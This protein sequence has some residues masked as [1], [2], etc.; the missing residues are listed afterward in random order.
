MTSLTRMRIKLLPVRHLRSKVKRA[1]AASVP[2]S[3]FQLHSVI[4]W[5][6][7]V[8][9]RWSSEACA[10]LY[11]PPWV[12]TKGPLHLLKARWRSSEHFFS[13]WLIC[14]PE[15]SYYSGDKDGIRTHASQHVST[16]QQQKKFCFSWLRRQQSRD[17][18]KAPDCRLESS[19]AAIQNH[20]W[21]QVLR[22]TCASLTTVLHQK[23]PKNRIV[24]ASAPV[25]LDNFTAV[26][27][28]FLPPNTTAT[29]QPLHQGV[30]RAVKQPYKKKLLLRFHLAIKCGSFHK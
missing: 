20:K 8:T 27:L 28:V 11:Q 10:I 4:K 23:A 5:R 13:Y 25:T 2:R 24:N 30:I 7:A 26:K 6:H 17:A 1:R 12:Q 29:A 18:S 3:R 14:C 21:L 22:S 16:C 9:Y 19:T 15:V